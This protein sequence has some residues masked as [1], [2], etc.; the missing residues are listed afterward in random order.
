MRKMRFA[1]ITGVR[2]VEVRERPLPSLGDDEVLVHQ[3]GCNI[4]TADYG[5]WLGKRSHQGFPMAGG[6]EGAGVVDAVGKSVKNLRVGDFVATFLYGCGECNYCL[7][8]KQSWCVSGN[9]YDDVTED[10]YHLGIFGF[11]DYSIRKAT[12]LIKMNPKLDSSEAG[13][14]EPLAT[15]VMG[16]RKLRAHPFESIVVIGGGTMGLLNALTLRSYGCR[17]IVSEI[18]DEKLSVARK[19]GFD[20]IDIKMDDPQKKVFDWTDGVGADAVVMGVANTD[21]NNQAFKLLK[22][23]DGRILYFAADY[24]SPELG[25]DSNGVH[26][27]RMELIGTIGADRVDFETAAQLL[28]T[29]IVNVSQLI[30]PQRYRLSEAQKAFE[31]AA[32]PNSFR[33]CI[34]TAE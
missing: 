1:C 22:H 13:F 33:V 7:Q 14:L 3:Y 11:A 25:I 6:H 12:E 18:M 17:V 10:G 15:V 24:P 26:Y 23:K 21:A 20:T 30:E 5:Q 31:H 28:N 27:K 4:C 9:G 29:G 16:I 32:N 2:N 8:G 19:M 34:R